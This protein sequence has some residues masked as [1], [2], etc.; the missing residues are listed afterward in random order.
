MPH[1]LRPQ[2]PRTAGGRIPP[3]HT[4]G[5]LAARP[6]PAASLNHHL[7]AEEPVKDFP[8]KPSSIRLPRDTHRRLKA[9]AALAEREMPDLAAEILDAALCKPNPRAIG[10]LPNEVKK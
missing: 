8:A 4:I 9:A 6:Q 2:Q 3:T 1:E 7:T 5:A 10:V